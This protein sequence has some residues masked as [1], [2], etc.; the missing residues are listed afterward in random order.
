M[1]LDTITVSPDCATC[2]KDGQLCACP[3]PADF[4]KAAADDYEQWVAATFEG[5]ARPA[6][7]GIGITADDLHKHTETCLQRS[8]DVFGIS[9]LFVHECICGGNE[10]ATADDDSGEP[11]LAAFVRSFDFQDDGARWPAT[12]QR[13]DDGETVLYAGKV[14]SVYGTPGTGKTWVAILAAIET[15]MRGGRVIWW[16]FE[17]TPQTFKRRAALLGFDPTQYTD[18]FKMVQPDMADSELAIAQAQAWLGQ[19]P[20][21]ALV[22]IDAAESAGCPSDGSEVNTW[23]RGYVEPWAT[24][25]S[26]VLV[27][28]H[29]PKQRDGRPPG[30][31]GSQRKRAM[32][33][34]ASIKV[35]GVCWTPKTNGRIMLYNEKDRPGDLPAPVGKAI[36][37]IEGD[38]QG[39]GDARGFRVKI[40]APANQDGDTVA[41]LPMAFLS[42]L[43]DEVDGVR[44]KR[45]LLT[46]VKGAQN[47]KASAVDGLVAAGM[48]AKSRQGK[49][50]V[51]TITAHGMQ[52]LGA[53]Y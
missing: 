9:P 19:S 39:D 35:D 26:G 13:H 42:A 25:G 6:D 40:V 50:D 30:A 24:I 18:Q 8:W 23:L 32:I 49:T 36:A 15:V 1:Q 27:V 51:F 46:M 44:G 10:D 28:D 16:D 38:W 48:I 14:N 22:V 37:V 31:I 12:L 2:G 53:D 5:L 33:T 4:G 3:L 43:A 7:D 47:D 41:D 34:G 20:E 17:D 11:G 45:N 21:P 29:V 52:M